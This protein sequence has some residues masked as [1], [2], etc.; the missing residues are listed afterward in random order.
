MSDSGE[1]RSPTAFA[2]PADGARGAEIDRLELAGATG[3]DAD[4]RAAQPDAGTE[5]DFDRAVRKQNGLN[6]HALCDL[7]PANA[8]PR[9]GRRI[10]RRVEK[11][12]TAAGRGVEIGKKWRDARGARE[13]ARH[14]AIR[15]RDVVLA[16]GDVAVGVHEG[17]RLRCAEKREPERHCKFR[18]VIVLKR[19]TGAE[20][21]PEPGRDRCHVVA[22]PVAGE[23]QMLL[24]Q[25]EDVGGNDDIADVLDD[26]DLTDIGRVSLGGGGRLEAAITSRRVHPEAV[27]HAPLRVRIELRPRFAR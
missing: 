23:L 2:P 21:R 25:V 7:E 24:R 8:A 17:A 12:A 6:G 22:G 3:R 26:G 4:D 27:Q 5:M 16:K 14:A 19:Q 9:D 15:A 10:R 18:R 11:D 13:K 1:N 20:R